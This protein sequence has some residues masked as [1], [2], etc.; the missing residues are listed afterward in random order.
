MLNLLVTNK[1]LIMTRT[2]LSPSVSEKPNSRPRTQAERTALAE[3]R[4]VAAAIELLNTVGIE[5]ATLKAI[6]EKA[7]Y[8]RGLATHHFGTKAGLFRKLLREVSASWVRAL[9]AKVASKTG[10]EALT[11]ANEAHLQHVLKHPD[12]LRAMYILWFGSLDPG[13]EFKPNLS[14]FMRVQRESMANWVRSGQAAG[15]IRADVD[16]ERTGEQLY[17][18]LI[19]INHQWLVDPD[20]DLR[21]AYREMKENMLHWLKA[22]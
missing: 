5:G 22:E 13:S 7:G 8:S 16:P 3:E 11:A 19:G 21:L 12:H 10:M 18:S 1:F 17:A 6:G 9:Q 2:Q 14:G 4:M 20:L 15:E